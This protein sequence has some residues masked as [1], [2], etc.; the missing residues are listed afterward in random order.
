MEFKPA[1]AFSTVS[2]SNYH[3]IKVKYPFDFGDQPTFRIKDLVVFRPVCYL[4]NHRIKSCVLDTTNNEIT[5]SFQFALATSTAYHL[6]FS[7]LDP[8]NTDIDGFLASLAVSNVVLM[9]KNHGGSWRF[10]ETDQFPAL[11]SLPS[12]A[13]AGPFRGIVSGTATYGHEVASQLNFV[14]LLLG[15]NRTDITGLVFE[16]PTF[17]KNGNALYS[18]LSART[19]SFLNQDDGGS[20]PCGNNGYSAGGNV[21]C[22]LLNG[23]HSNLGTPTRIIM[24]D[25]TYSTQMNC[26]FVFV[27]H[28][29]TNTYFSVMVRAFGGTPTADNPYGDKYMGH[30]EFN[31]IFRV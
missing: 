24:T 31:E 25:F 28:D 30:W 7:I 22:I 23:D 2:G 5:M 10:T 27:N 26:R 6:K 20:Y 12:G 16:I 11:L 3:M 13:S 29:R 15:F 17:D 21:R 18:S 19:T 9:Y 4:A 14:N 8:R 1:V